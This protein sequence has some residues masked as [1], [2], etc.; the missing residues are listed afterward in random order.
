MGIDGARRVHDILAIHAA[1]RPSA[2]AA[3]DG[4]RRLSYGE[5]SRAVDTMAK[6]LLAA[7]VRPGDRVATLAAPSIDFWV[8]FLAT[9]SI[10]ATWL[11][12]NPKYKER[13]YAHV[14]SDAAPRVVLAQSPLEGR[15][16]DSELQAVGDKVETFVTSGEPAGRAVAVEAFLAKGAAVL[17]SELAAA[18][19][20]VGP[21]DIAAIVYTSGTTGKP[22]G[23]MLSHRAV[24]ACAKANLA[25]AGDGLASS[26]QPA[27]INHVG[28]LNN[29][30]MNVLAY[31]GK[32]VFLHKVDMVAAQAL[33]VAEAPSLMVTSP[34]GFLMLLNAPGFTLDAIRFTRCIMFGGAATPQAILEKFMP[35]G[36]R[37]ASVYGQTETCGIITVTD[38]NADVATLAETIGKPLPGCEARIAD[39]ECRALGV[40]AVGEIQ[41]R[42][43]YCMSGYFNDPEATRNAFTA[44]GFLRTGDLGTWRDD[45][46]LVFVGRLKE[47]FKSGGYNIYP[48][49]IEQ[50]IAEHPA[51]QLAAVLPVPDPLYQEVGHAFV[52]PLSGQA[53]DA[54]DLRAFLRDRIA[55]YKVPK[56]FT[57]VPALP[58]LPNSKVDRLALRA[59]LAAGEA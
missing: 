49:E 45:G 17:D 23:A 5:L 4:G 1:E 40:G 43:P 41:L 22:R 56:S 35:L 26:L 42:G 39:A 31:G 16:Y 8:Q 28:A 52:Q 44:D 38:P 12:I 11:G 47:M 13:D 19:A 32:L 29:I 6:A 57:I 46:N 51:V 36:A 53:V 7:G 15:H 3:V 24:V 9:T 55:N 25:W 27:P 50:A 34:T 20:A 58:L 48:L 18:R 2:D 14:L 54:E 37:M 30:C 33:V 10:G 59:R 21:E